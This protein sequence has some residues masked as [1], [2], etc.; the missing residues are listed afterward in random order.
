MPA[1]S[2]LSTFI[3]RLRAAKWNI[4][5]ISVMLVLLYGAG[6]MLPEGFD[7]QHFFSHGVVPSLWT[8]WTPWVLRLLLPFGYPAIFALSALAIGMR[9][10]QYNTSPWRITL[11]FLSLPT[12][13]V[14]FMG[15]LDGLTL[16]GL[17]T[18]PWGVPLALMK[19]QIAAFALLAKRRYL[20]SAVIFL[21]ISF[22]LW[23]FWPQNLLTV[24]TPQWQT[25]WQQD[26]NLFP[27]GMLI[28]IPLLW[29]SRGDSD[30]LMA[31]GSL[32]TPHLFPY[33]FIL[34]MPA[35]A[36][37]SWRWAVLTWIVSWTPLL[38]NWVGPMGW[39]FGNLLSLCFW[40]GVY[41]QIPHRQLPGWQI[42][43]DKRLPWWQR[44]DT[45]VF[46]TPPS[47]EQV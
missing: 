30:L 21:L 10:Y 39:H 27:Y 16:L 32:I 26:I 22:L 18:L 44:L 23:G 3:A 2:F 1:T 43:L 25:E 31:A 4:A 37:M 12:L 6:H 5:I 46:A 29:Y 36:R 28:G 34:L 40:I 17:I 24:L 20:L 19:P 7:W 38:S 41:S 42:L 11:A 15:N 45:W 9:A 13:W 33:H 8:P 47:P 14:F 35:I